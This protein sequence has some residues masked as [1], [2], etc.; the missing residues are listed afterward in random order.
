MGA[1]RV[2]HDLVTEQQIHNVSVVLSLSHVKNKIKFKKKR[3]ERIKK[4]NKQKK[5]ILYAS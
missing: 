2:R 5:T 1:Q 4:Q 3:K